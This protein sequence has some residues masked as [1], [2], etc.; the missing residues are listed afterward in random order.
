MRNAVFTLLSLCLLSTYPGFGQGQTDTSNLAQTNIAYVYNVEAPI[1]FDARVAMGA[2]EATVFLRVTD[3]SQGTAFSVRYEVRSAYQ[4]GE[5]LQANTLSDQQLRKQAGNQYYYRFSLPVTDNS[6]YIFV[7]AQQTL[8]GVPQEFRYDIA[9]NTDQNFPLTDL[10]LMQAQEDVPIFDNFVKEGTDF[11]IVSV[12]N[13]D[14]SAYLYYYSHDFEPNPPPMSTGGGDVQ[15]SLEIDS[16]FQISLGETLAFE[17][18]GMYFVQTDTTLL[19]GLSFRVESEYYPRLVAIEKVIEPLRYISTSE[20][21]DQLTENDE[22]KKALDQYWLKMTRSQERAK[23]II[24]N[25]YRQVTKANQLF[26]SYKEGWKTGQGMIYVLYGQPDAVYRDNDRETWV[27]NAD[28][29]L[30]DLSFTF[31]Q[32]KNIFTHSYYN[33]VRDEDYKRFWYRNID[34]WRKGRKE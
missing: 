11:R 26:T 29:N 34:L 32:V 18:E 1:R 17:E 10:V 20:E 8:E 24:R 19:S 27:Y 12:Y 2:S 3:Q 7:Y 25:Y 33:L 28:R 9:L 6:H 4:G 14:S 5:V 22:S 13:Q 31:S 23:E 15:K 16:L 30:V 21:M